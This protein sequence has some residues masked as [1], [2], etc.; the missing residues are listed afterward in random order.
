MLVKV[1]KVCAQVVCHRR[2]G[3]LSAPQPSLGGCGRYWPTVCW[4]LDIL[5]NSAS[6]AAAAVFAIQEVAWLSQPLVPRHH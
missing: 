2:L 1:K 5:E 4:G 6:S 3:H